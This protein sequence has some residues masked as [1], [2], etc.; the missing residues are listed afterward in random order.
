MPLD[1]SLFDWST[2]TAASSAQLRTSGGASRDIPA[3]VPPA[4]TPAPAPKPASNN[5]GSSSSGYQVGGWYDGR[6]WDGNRFGAPGEVIVG[7]NSGGSSG[8]SSGPSLDDQ[9][10]REIDSQYSNTMNYLSQLE[11]NANSDYTS[12]LDMTKQSFDQ[13]KTHSQQTYAQNQKVYD[14]NQDEVNRATKSALS[15]AVRA[16]NALA[17]QRISRFGGG[18]SAGEA[19]GELANQEYFRQQGGIQETSLRNSREIQAARENLALIQKQFEDNLE[20]EYQNEMSGLKKELNNTLARIQ[21]M[22][23]ETENAKSQMRLSAIQDNINRARNVQLSFIE[24]GLA[25]R[26]AIAEK[27]QNYVSL[28]NEYKSMAE[29]IDYEGGFNPYKVNQFIGSNLSQRSQGS[30][31]SYNFNPYS[32]STDDDENQVNPFF[33]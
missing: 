20:L 28:L 17:Q 22:R 3:Y 13:A 31:N 19:V 12:A 32:R 33:N 7:G 27:D 1:L 9:L 24:R 26:E 8:G 15:D 29:S 23:V 16:Y 10:R 21:G 6:Q 18:S 5:T 11:S 14:T 2:P 30:T 25:A 4:P